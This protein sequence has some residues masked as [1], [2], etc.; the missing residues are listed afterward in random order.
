MAV[1]V[2]VETIQCRGRLSILS[3]NHINSQGQTPWQPW[4][5]SLPIQ[6][7]GVSLVSCSTMGEA[8]TLTTW[9]HPSTITQ[10]PT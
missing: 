5:Q 6:T 1:V 8:I 9:I 3:S 7:W 2:E 10:W 4:Q